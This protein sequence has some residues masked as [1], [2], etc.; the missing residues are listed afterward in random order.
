MPNNRPAVQK[1]YQQKPQFKEYK[2]VY[3]LNKQ[4]ERIRSIASEDGPISLAFRNELTN[5]D[6]IRDVRIKTKEYFGDRYDE[7]IS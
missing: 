3:Y 1:K 2:R 5:L 4:K 6:N 7:L